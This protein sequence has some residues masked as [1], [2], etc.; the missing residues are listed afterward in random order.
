MVNERLSAMRE[1]FKST[2]AKYEARIAKLQH[3]VGQMKQQLE[4]RE[5]DSIAS[6]TKLH[7]EWATE[8]EQVEASM[9]QT[10]DTARKQ[11]CVCVA[12]AQRCWR[13]SGGSRLASAFRLWSACQPHAPP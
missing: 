9:A 11:V 10:M 5:L 6:E 7:K 8:L 4:Q 12:N 3:R 2:K 13:R 1:E